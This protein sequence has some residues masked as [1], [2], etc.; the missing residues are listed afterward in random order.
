MA[1][2]PVER[3]ATKLQLTWAQVSEHPQAPSLPNL[4]RQGPWEPDLFS[5]FSCS[6]VAA[7]ALLAEGTRGIQ[8][9][10]GKNWWK[11]ES[12]LLWQPYQYREVPLFGSFPNHFKYGF[13][14]WIKKARQ[15]APWALHHQTIYCWVKAV[16]GPGCS[17]FSLY[18]EEATFEEHGA[19]DGCDL[20]PTWRWPISNLPLSLPLP[21]SW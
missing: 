14:V 2:L 17:Q 4:E 12:H 5:S 15:I 13:L 20:W 11:A 6:N 19:D 3:I 10:E 1:G 21:T 9:G 8:K 16:Q 7:P 18:W